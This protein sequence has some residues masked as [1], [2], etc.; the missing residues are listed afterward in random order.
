MMR[1]KL[2]IDNLV[3][4]GL[5]NRIIIYWVSVLAYFAIGQVVFQWID[6]PELSFEEHCG[7]LM[8]TFGFWLPGLALLLPLIIFDIVKLSHRFVGPIYRLKKFLETVDTGKEKGQLWFRDGDFWSELVDPVN[9]IVNR[10]YTAEAK[11]TELKVRLNIVEREKQS[12]QYQFD[13]M[14]E[15]V[16]A[17]AEVKGEVKPTIVPEAVLKG[18]SSIPGTAVQS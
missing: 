1:R 16:K 10:M 4:G 11:A 9:R 13:Q 15:K 14:K 12:L 8:G 2:W 3:Q 17:S 5:V 18:N 7:A 6:R